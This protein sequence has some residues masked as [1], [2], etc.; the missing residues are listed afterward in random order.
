M[1]LSLRSHARLR[2]RIVIKKQGRATPL[3]P[4]PPASSRRRRKF[5]NLNGQ[6]KN[7][8]NTD[9]TSELDSIRIQRR[10]PLVPPADPRFQSRS[11]R[12]RGHL[13]AWGSRLGGGFS[14]GSL[15]GFSQL[16]AVTPPG[17]APRRAGVRQAE[18]P[19]AHV[20][21][22]STPILFASPRPMWPVLESNRAGVISPPWWGPVSLPCPSSPCAHGPCA[23][24]V[25]PPLH[26]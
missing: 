5:A 18:V 8:Y 1:T 24:F 17:A 2:T 25:R 23:E 20:D 9:D 4:Q 10:S 7:F 11:H 21:V 22:R 26:A 13:R 6:R 15:T 12:S 14:S 19:M 16:S 3:L